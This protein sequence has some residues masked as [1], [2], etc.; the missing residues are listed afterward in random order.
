MGGLK[1]V[2]F[3][4]TAESNYNSIYFAGSEFGV[5]EHE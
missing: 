5:G 4:K 2:S 3:C 1:K